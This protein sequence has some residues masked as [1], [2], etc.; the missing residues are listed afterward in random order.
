[1][2]IHIRLCKLND[3]V[4]VGQLI[5]DTIR[6]VNRKDYSDEQINAW[7]PD[8]FIYSTFEESY[9]YI[10]EYEGQ[11][12]GFGN[13]NSKGYLCRFYVH[14]DFQGQGIGTLLLK[15]LEQKANELGLDEIH[16]EASISAKPFFLSKG[17][18]ETE[19]QTKVYKG[20]SFINYKMFKKIK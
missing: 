19:E 14:K 16:T 11:I 7:A 15:A 17:W 8:P 9:A 5:F 13:L 12:V 3:H 2:P 10:A 4:Q 6:T 18:I 1:M 20:V